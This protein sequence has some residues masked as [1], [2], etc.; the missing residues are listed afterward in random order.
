M[1]TGCADAG[2][3]AVESGGDEPR[4]VAAGGSLVVVRPSG[5]VCILCCYTVPARCDLFLLSPSVGPFR[6]TAGET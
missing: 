4:A 2:A 5:S 3:G 1:P 6:A